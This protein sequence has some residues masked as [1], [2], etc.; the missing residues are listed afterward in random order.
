MDNEVWKDIPG[1]A[2]YQ[3]S[4]Q[5]RVRS[6]RFGTGGGVK[7]KH[8]R[9]IT[10]SFN[11]RK[12]HLM[13][14]LVCLPRKRKQFQLHRLLYEVFIGPIPEGVLVEH[15]DRNGLNNNLEN[16]RLSNQSQNVVNQK[17]REGRKYKGVYSTKSGKWAV[18]TTYNKKCVYLGT[19]DTEREAIEAYNKYAVEKFGEFAV[20]N[21]FKEEMH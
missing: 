12:S 14:D 17:V 19:F 1:F 5:G 11:G 7:F 20:L 21:V 13:V 2:G 18:Q 8:W 15:R 3:I 10:P 16:L 4:N 6:C 9:E